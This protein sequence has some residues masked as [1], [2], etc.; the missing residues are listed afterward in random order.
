MAAASELRLRADPRRRGLGARQGRRGPPLP[1]ITARAAPAR[2]AVVT[3]R[4]PLHDETP[5]DLAAFRVFRGV[6][7]TR[8]RLTDL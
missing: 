5:P 2:D 7:V 3:V 4:R 6:S 1:L 8:R